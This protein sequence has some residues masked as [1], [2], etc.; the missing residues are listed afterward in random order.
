MNSRDYYIFYNHGNE[1]MKKKNNSICVYSDDKNEE[2]EYKNL[3]YFD[4]ILCLLNYNYSILSS[5]AIL[6][7]INRVIKKN[8][9]SSDIH[10]EFPF[11]R[12]FC[13][14][15]LLFKRTFQSPIR[16]ILQFMI[17]SQ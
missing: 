14:F 11:Y 10:E 15:F 2:N 9:S 16:I 12:D 17:I 8:A 7:I 13:S 5:I 6:L 4:S 1:R 3:L